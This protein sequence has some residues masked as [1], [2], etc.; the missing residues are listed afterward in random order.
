MHLIARELLVDN[1]AV[2]VEGPAGVR[3]QNAS[4]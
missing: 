4:R 3:V 2:A 1:E